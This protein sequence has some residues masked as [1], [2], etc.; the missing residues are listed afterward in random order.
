VKTEG[1]RAVADAGGIFW[2]V[3]WGLIGLASTQGLV[4]S[5]WK[6]ADAAL[7]GAGKALASPDIVDSTLELLEPTVR[8][9]D[10][11]PPARRG[12]YAF[13]TFEIAEAAWPEFSALST[14]A[15]K[16][17][18]PGYDARIF[19]LFRYL[20]VP[21]PRRRLLLFTN[22][23]SMAVWEKSRLRQLHRGGD[24]SAPAAKANLSARLD[25]TDWSRV[26]I[27]VPA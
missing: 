11:T 4:F 19:G 23:P 1:A 24:D 16:T 26:V 20:A 15:W 9:T 5:A 14:G 10:H 13:R 21:P 12:V 7:A 3:W 6:D 2:G 17:F 8:P 25:V 27:G 18:E 22:Y